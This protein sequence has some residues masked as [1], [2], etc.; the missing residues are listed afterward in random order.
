MTIY[1]H[2]ATI[3]A[4]AEASEQPP[5]WYA[6]GTVIAALPLLTFTIFL[7]IEYPMLAAVACAF[8]VGAFTVYMPS[9]QKP[10]M[11]VYKEIIPKR[12]REV[13]ISHDRVY[14]QVIQV[15]RCN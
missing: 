10:E 2:V 13:M 12:K 4:Y 14:L 7:A 11:T 8:C 9:H 3:K 15:E 5:Q 6:T 1:D